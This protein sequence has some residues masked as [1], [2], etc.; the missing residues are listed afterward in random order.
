MPPA[1]ATG[2]GGAPEVSV[3]I[4]THGRETRLAFALEALAAQTLPLDRFE[5]IVVRPESAPTP[6]ATAPSGLDVVSVSWPGRPSRPGQRNAGWRAAKGR[7]A[8]FT[9]DDCRPAPHW[10]DALVTSAAS[11]RIVV[12]GRTDP[13]PDEEHL[14][15]GLARSIKV[16]QGDPWYPTCN[17]AYPRAL[18][19][20]LDG[21][22][23]EFVASGEDT[24]LALRALERGA[25]VEFCDEAVVWHAV[26]PQPLNR[27]VA[28]GWQRWESTPLI[29]KRH[30]QHRAHLFGRVFYNRSHAALALLALAAPFARRRPRLSLVGAGPF[31]IEG[32]D[33]SNLG[34]RGLVRQAL[35]SPARLLREG[36]LTAGLLRGAVRHGTPV[37]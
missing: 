26:L 1:N 30:P 17:I 13:D 24:D 23:E 6:F 36:A 11:N 19:E 7:L 3:V 2:G 18:L 20:E 15:H 25:R 12:Q 37:F 27:A 34:P 14:L 22:D 8:A 10:L 32:L 31:A 33:T 5:V 35:H 29:F 28:D 4:P 21:F 9:D 16:R